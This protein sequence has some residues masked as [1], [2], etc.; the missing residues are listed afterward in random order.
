MV[1]GESRICWSSGW[2]RRSHPQIS[3]GDQQRFSLRC[4]SFRNRAFATSLCSRGRRRCSF[5]AWSADWLCQLRLA[6]A[7]RLDLAPG[8]GEIVGGME[9]TEMRESARAV[10]AR[11]ASMED[12]RYGRRWTAEEIM[13]GFVG[14]VGDLAKLVQGKAGVRPTADLDG[15][16]AHE[17]ADCLWCVFTLADEYGVDLE[18]SF[19]ETM[20]FLTRYL[21]ESVAED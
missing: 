15:K 19:S 3:S 5:A 7:R 8:I 18:S 10:R 4:T 2:V 12:R 20:A 1:S 6:P 11:Y 21:D 13:L 16:V 17:L 14:D 9:F